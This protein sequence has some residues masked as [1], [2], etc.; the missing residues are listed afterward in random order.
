MDSYMSGM[1]QFDGTG[2]EVYSARILAVLSVKKVKYVLTAT[3]PEEEGPKKQWEKDN[4]LA[5]ATILLS[6]SDEMVRLVFACETAK[7]A[8]NRLQEVYAQHS[9]SS[10]MNLEHEFYSTVM[11]P[12]QKVS[13]YVAEIE[14]IAKKLRDAG[15]AKDDSTLISKIVS[16]LQPEFQHFRSMWMG[17]SE[18]ERTYANLL[19]RLIAE[20]SL[21]VK[22]VKEEP[23]ALK[24]S[25]RPD[26][27]TNKDKRNKKGKK[28]VEC[29]HC[30]KIGHIKSE[31]RTLKREQ[32]N[33]E[34]KKKFVIV[35]MASNTSRDR[36]CYDSGASF[37]M[38]SHREWFTDYR[39]LDEPISIEVGNKEYIDAVGVG[40]IDFVSIVDGVKLDVTVTEVHYVPEICSNLF[41]LGVADSKQIVAVAKNGKLDLIKEGT[42][43]IQ[44]TKRG[45]NMYILDI[46]VPGRANIAR[47]ERPLEE[48][49]RVLGHPDINEIKNLDSKGCADGFKIAERSGNERCAGCAS[50]KAHQAS[51]PNS[52]RERSLVPLHRVHTDLVGPIQPPTING[53]RYFMLL[54]DEYSSYMYAYFMRASH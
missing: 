51:H 7:S 48:W 27:S 21:V 8:W 9:E 52:D 44:S 13:T 26:K 6:L 33:S 15:V 16:G 12:G 22:K 43:I 19:P 47:A 32:E 35:A 17:T 38:T 10:K 24:A 31:C 34:D 40:S 49:H 37:H 18:A 5:K 3:K 2:Y 45:S 23:V 53:A 50:G 54:R 29:H 41:S 28:G 42:T 1:K 39:Q 36:W 25:V 11:Q 4:E 46:H 14:L 30:H 20:E